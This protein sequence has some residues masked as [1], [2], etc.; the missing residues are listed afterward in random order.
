MALRDTF[1]R[2]RSNADFLCGNKEEMPVQNH[3]TVSPVKLNIPI[4]IHTALAI[5]L[6]ICFVDSNHL[7]SVT[8]TLNLSIFANLNYLQMLPTLL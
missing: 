3:K 7:S 4:C 5:S 6:G 8:Y 1:R 2:V